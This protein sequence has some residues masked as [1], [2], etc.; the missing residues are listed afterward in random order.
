MNAKILIS[1]LSV[2]LLPSTDVLSRDRSAAPIGGWVLV[3]DIV[4]NCH[5]GFCD[6]EVV[7]A[8]LPGNT[9]TVRRGEVLRALR[10]AG[11]ESHGL[12]IPERT[13]IRRGA[14]KVDSEV[15]NRQIREKIESVLPSGTL[16][17]KLDRIDSFSVPQSG[18]SI[19]VTWS[20]D[21]DFRRRVSIP[22]AL[23]SDGIAFKRLQLAALLE[24]E[25]EL[26]VASRKLDSGTVIGPDD[27]ERVRLRMTS[28]P[29]NLAL[30]AEQVYGRV[31][32]NPVD[33]GAPFA[34][35]SLESVP[36]VF[37]QQAVAVEHS[38][39]S[40]RVTVAGMARMNGAIGDRIRVIL[41]S[42]NR[43]VW[44][45]VSGPGKASVVP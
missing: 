33:Q 17:E 36:V 26:P 22:V 45:V 14:V 31:L 2:L 25:V 10:D 21:A 32:R 37:D 38:I 19:E 40:I 29:S 5:A 34:L 28:S 16:I 18:Y 9:R 20:G 11:Y 24:L 42:D 6:I 41:S 13:R 39:G 8:P 15:I 3:R 1:I 30:K 23:V 43:L 27:M 44:A 4:D 35:R 12:T 7:R